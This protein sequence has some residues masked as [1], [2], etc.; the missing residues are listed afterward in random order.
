[1]S[2][3]DKA[4]ET[5]EERSARSDRIEELTEMV[6]CED[7]LLQHEH[8]VTQDKEADALLATNQISTAQN[9]ATGSSA[10][11][12]ASDK[13]PHHPVMPENKKSNLGR[14]TAFEA[15][16]VLLLRQNEAE[17][18]DALEKMVTQNVELRYELERERYNVK[19]WADYANLLLNALEE[20][21]LPAPMVHGAYPDETGYSVN[22][23]DD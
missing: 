12:G 15:G 13:R 2:E 21:E 1:M 6:E 7:F 11:M 14:L 18:K 22:T 5:A 10:P 4:T 8:L 20:Y 23:D 17:S 9:H 19:Y 16:L 3:A